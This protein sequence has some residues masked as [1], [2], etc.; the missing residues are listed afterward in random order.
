[1]FGISLF[2]LMK[3]DTTRPVLRESG[4]DESCLRAWDTPEVESFHV[5]RVGV[6]SA[7]GLE[8]WDV[9]LIESVTLKT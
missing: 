7:G 6:P 3:K 5:S 4:N 2:R 1:M 8:L 9:T